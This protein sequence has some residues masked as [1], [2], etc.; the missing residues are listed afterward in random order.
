M[1]SAVTAL[2]V[3]AC[4][5]AIFSTTKTGRR[6][7]DAL[8]LRGPGPGAATSDDVDFLLG[9]CDNDP[10]EVARRIDAER[11]RYPDLCEADHYRRAIRR[12]LAEAK[13]G[14]ETASSPGAEPAPDRRKH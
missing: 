12:L 14:P 2:V 8:G 3:L 7:F 11:E 4:V 13:S 9:R 10:K 1:L 5:L 6:V